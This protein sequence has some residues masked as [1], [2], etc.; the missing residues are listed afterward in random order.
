MECKLCGMGYIPENPDD[1]HEHE[2]YHDKIVNGL[3]SISSKKEST[4]W[5]H[6]D[7]KITVVNN[8]SS[9]ECRKKAEEVGILARRDTPYGAEVLFGEF[10]AYVFLLHKQNRI[11]GFLNIDKRDSYAQMSWTDFEIP[12]DINLHEISSIWCVCM[13]WILL[14]YRRLSYANLVLEKALN[15]LQSNLNDVA[16]YVPPITDLGKAF[17]RNFYPDIFYVAR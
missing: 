17:M 4:I 2:I 12:R 7:L 5:L 1:V 16:W 14:K 6:D 15:Y 10:E 11:I 8:T 9:E 13:I 3:Y